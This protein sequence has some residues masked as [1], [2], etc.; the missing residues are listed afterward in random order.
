[1]SDSA[2]STPVSRRGVLKASAA[3]ATFATLG[4]NFAHAQG[5]QTI[6]IGLVGC[7]GR[8]RGAAG[9]A[10]SSSQGVQ[11]IA[12]GDLFEDKAKLALTDFSKRPKEKGWAVSADKTFWGWD[13]YKQVLATDIDYVILATPPGFRPMMVRAAIEAGKNV[14]AEKPVCVDPV[15]AR[16]IMESG[17]L[18][19]QKK[20]AIVAGTQR[21]H[22]PSYIE[23]IK[24]LKDGAIG[25]IM[26][27]SVGWLQGATRFTPRKEGWSDVEWYIRNWNYHTWLSGDIITEQHVHQIDV[28]NWVIGKTPKQC[29]SMG[30][31]ALRTLPEYGNIYDFFAT[32]FEYP[33]GQKVTS[34]SR[35]IDNC[36]TRTYET[37]RGTKGEAFAEGKIE[38]A[39]GEI[40][41]FESDEDI[42]PYVQEHKDLIASIR[43]GQ[44][45]N[46]AQRVAE[47]CLSAIMARISAYTGNLV[48]WVDVID[49]GK[50]KGIYADIDLMPKNL[51]FGPMEQRPVS[52]PGTNNMPGLPR[53]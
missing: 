43:A 33:D 5:S 30:F 52:L 51:A 37:F 25:E 35:Q 27:G 2:N 18:A 39:G 11:L 49:T 22:Q 8:G 3:A 41:H 32:E 45:L 31:R 46:E 20:L 38:P 13:A 47:S 21:R 14:F 6:K 15:G 19:A 10:L 7:G 36:Y 26:T 28:A 4:T 17:K 50:R 9:N 23:T 53:K 42:N 29:V 40:W 1:M 44:P 16:S 24:R 34:M 12:L 48:R